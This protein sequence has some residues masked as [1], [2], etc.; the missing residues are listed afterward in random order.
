MP[1]QFQSACPRRERLLS[2]QLL[3]SSQCTDHYIPSLFLCERPYPLP[4]LFCTVYHSNPWA[5]T[6]YLLAPSSGMQDTSVLIQVP[7]AELRQASGTHAASAMR[8][9]TRPA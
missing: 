9:E 1:V 8:A 7:Q 2:P 3:L 4:T 5:P 6:A